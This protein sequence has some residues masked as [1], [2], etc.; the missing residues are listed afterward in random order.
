ML[1]DSRF[2]PDT[3]EG[4]CRVDLEISQGKISSIVLSGSTLIKNPFVDLKGGIIFPGFV[5]IHTHLDK[6]HIW[7]R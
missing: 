7:E 3:R 4:L 2:T 6:S 1:D 5:D